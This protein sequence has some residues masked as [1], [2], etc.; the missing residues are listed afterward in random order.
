MFWQIENNTEYAAIDYNYKWSLQNGG[1][2]CVCFSN[3]ALQKATQFIL[4]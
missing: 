3:A 2:S 4:K 1:K